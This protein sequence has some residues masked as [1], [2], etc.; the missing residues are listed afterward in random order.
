MQDSLRMLIARIPEPDVPVSAAIAAAIEHSV[1]YLA[2][3]A[4]L[5][6]INR[7]TYWP[8]WDSPWWHMVLLHE[9]VE[10]RRIPARV[11]AA[12]ADG[13]N[14]LP[15]RIFPIHD[16]DWPPGSDR[17]R[18]STCHCALGC[19]TQ[20]LA[21]CGLDVD[22]RLPWVKPWFV[23]YQMADGG[24]NCDETAYLVTDECPSS[25]VGTIA[26]FEA[27]LLGDPARWTDEHRGFLA[28]AARCL[29]DRQ[30]VLGSPTR[31]NAGE[32]D[33]QA[34]WLLPC[35]PRFYFYDVVRGLSALVRWAEW[36]GSE[37]PRAAVAP[38]AEH[39]AAA[40]PDGVVRIGRRAFDGKATRAPAPDGT[41]SVRRPASTF[42]LLEATS[43]IGAACPYSTREWTA[44]R[45]GLARL[46]EAG[47]IVTGA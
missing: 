35:R 9:V 3:D 41:W 34:D 33:A 20:V 45:Q 39:L 28:R 24:L 17:G 4:A 29:I 15:V 40:F 22:A 6:S 21:A 7:E 5:A 23:R 18:D 32:R 14:A 16:E 19:M 26:P 44:A 46:L 42:P 38:A 11:A 2:S 12:M 36:T 30:L 1:R 25:M 37:L 43:V 10:A 27:M 13:L 31:H 47:R 8:K